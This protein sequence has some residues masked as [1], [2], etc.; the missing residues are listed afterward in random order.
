MFFDLAEVEGTGRLARREFLH[1]HEKLRG[2]PLDGHDHK[3]TIEPPVVIGVR[4]VLCFLEG[5]AAQV[6]DQRRTQLYVRLAP[7]TEGLT[8]VFEES[9]FP[10]LIAGGHDLT[11]VAYIPEL[12]ARRFLHLAAE[13]VELVVAVEV[14]LV[15]ST[16]DLGALEELFLDV[17]RAGGGSEGRQPI[18]VGDEPIERLA[19]REMTGPTDEAR[20]AVGAFPVRIFL[21]AEGRGACIRPGVVVRA[22]VRG[23]LNDGVVGDAEVVNELEQFTHVQIVLDHAVAVIVLSVDAGEA[24]VFLFDVSAEVHARAIPPAEE[25]LAGLVLASDEV[26]RCGQ[27]FF[28]DGFHALLGE[29]AEVLDGLATL[30][31]SFAFENAARTELLEEFR[32]LRVVGVLGFLLGIEVVKA[33]DELIEAVHRRQ[34]FVEIA[35]VVLAELAGGIALALEDRG[36]GA[37]GLLPALRRRRAGRPWSCLSGPGRSR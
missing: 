21:T 37:V 30:A 35:L 32:I 33:A 11:I 4:V 16:I 24:L 26:L 15:A 29:R 31:V 6:A 8:A 22:V 18:L 34:M 2:Q 28:V 5:I 1:G 27:G 9:H 23:I 12:V 7:D 20:H 19:R 17:R 3:R 10:V 36:H 14:V 13:V 25:R